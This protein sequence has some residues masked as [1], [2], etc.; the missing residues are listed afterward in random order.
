MRPALLTALL[1]LAG[2][3][4]GGAATSTAPDPGVSAK[5]ETAEAAPAN[6]DSSGVPWGD[7]GVDWSRPPAPGPEPVF[8]IPRARSF[9][10]DNGLDVYV[11]ENPRLPLVTLQ[12][13]NEVGGSLHEP[14]RLAGLASLTADMLD[15]GAGSLQALEFAAAVERLGATLTTGAGDDAAYITMTTLAGNLDGSLALLTDVLRD[16][17]LSVP[18]FRRV[19]GDRISDLKKRQDQPT[20]VASVVFY[21][22]IFGRD[23]AYGTPTAGYVETV[24]RIKPSDLKTFY[25][26]NYAPD[27]MSLVVAGAVDADDLRKRLNRTLGSWRRKARPGKPAPVAAIDSPPRLVMVHKPGAAQSVV[28]LGRVTLDRNDPRYYT[29]E[30]LNGVLGG[31]FSARLNNVLREQLGYTYGARSRFDFGRFDS[32]WVMRTSIFSAKTMPGI[33]R[34]RAIVDQVS[35]ERVP[36]EELARV[37]QRLVRQLPQ[38]FQS[39]RGIAASY[40]DLVSNGLALDWYDSYAQRIEAVTA[41]EV[42]ALATELLAL[43]KLTLVVVGDLDLLRAPLLDL[44]LRPAVE[45]NLKGKLL[46]TFD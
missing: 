17:R 15:E 42:R 26:R 30:V 18:D 45:V 38:G 7:S 41:D 25:V 22:S 3:A 46:K 40:L 16:P 32:A 1:C 24:A 4:C 10:L 20:A 14:P 29:A 43:D 2:P 5:A 37:K 12:L 44:G 8:E 28:G 19:K 33:E 21:Q 36:D 34:A 27:R 39:N 23:S 9:Q 35:K 31:S 6:G 13:V 11:V